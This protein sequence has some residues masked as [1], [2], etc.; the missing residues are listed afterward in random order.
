MPFV[1]MNCLVVSAAAQTPLTWPEVRAKFEATNPTLRAD[2]LGIDESRASEITAFLRPNPQ[3]TSSFDQ[4]GHTEPGAPFDASTL[5]LAGSYLH[6]RQQKRELRRDSAQGATTIAIS[7]DADLER[8]LL[9]TLRVSFVQVLQARG[10]F[11]LTGENLA[12]YDQV[13]AVS[14]TRLQ[15]GDMRKRNA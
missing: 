6:E 3:F 15:S 13:L 12:A 11:V 7:G 10:L 9:S 1:R 5:L 8:L 4:I 2:Q 14:R